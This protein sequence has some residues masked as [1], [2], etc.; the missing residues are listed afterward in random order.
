MGRSI[1]GRWWVRGGLGRTESWPPLLGACLLTLLVFIESILPRNT[2]YY[3]LSLVVGPLRINPETLLIGVSSVV[4]M[5]WY[6]LSARRR[7]GKAS[8]LVILAL[9]LATLLT[10]VVGAVRGNPIKFFSA[11]LL[12]LFAF[13][14]FPLGMWAKRRSLDTMLLLMSAAFA[15][16]IVV[17]IASKGL[18]G[19]AAFYQSGLGYLV[20]PSMV[21]ALYLLGT[22]SLRRPLRLAGSLGFVALVVLVIWES[23]TRGLILGAVVGILVLAMFQ[24]NARRPAAILILAGV[25]VFCIAVWVLPHLGVHTVSAR[26]D[27]MWSR[28]VTISSRVAQAESL[29]RQMSPADWAIGRG[30]GGAYQPFLVNTPSPWWNLQ[31][32]ATYLD[33]NFLTLLLKGGMVL[34]LT[35]L[36]FLWTFVSRGARRPDRYTVAAL[37]GGTGL[38]AT[39]LVDSMSTPLCCLVFAVLCGS[40]LAASPAPDRAEATATSPT[41]SQNG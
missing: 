6:L 25:V 4:L 7:I 11:D 37:A 23:Q 19:R 24:K 18:H 39:N 15:I 16:G 35:F 22:M 5:I 12:A 1:V 40:V 33:F 41:V 30:L 3:T 27:S 9:I 31:L 13:G 26:V 34:V 20:A 29:V 28:T 8:R 14:V 32:G 21:L 36:A 10:V 38:L 17:I 2:W